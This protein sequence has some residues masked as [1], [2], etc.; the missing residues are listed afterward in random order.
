MGARRPR[1]VKRRELLE[2]R[3]KKK[4]RRREPKQKVR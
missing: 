3:S 4:G 2:L 1:T